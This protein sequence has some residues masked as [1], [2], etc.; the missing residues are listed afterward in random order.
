MTTMHVLESDIAQK[1]ESPR[2]GMGC[3][4]IVVGCTLASILIF[5]LLGYPYYHTPRAWLF[6]TVTVGIVVAEFFVI[7]LAAFVSQAVKNGEGKQ[8][9]DWTGEYAHSIIRWLRLKRTLILTSPLRRFEGI[10]REKNTPCSQWSTGYFRYSIFSLF[11]RFVMFVTALAW[12][13]GIGWTTAAHWRE[14]TF[15]LSIIDI[16]SA[17][18]IL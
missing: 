3:A 1:V 7:Y 8:Q 4:K 9:W 2:Q 12:W 14:V 13:A 10:S 6:W 5:I 15:A 16:L 17:H 18:R 11:S